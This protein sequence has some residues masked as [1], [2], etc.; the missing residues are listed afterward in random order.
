LYSIKNTTFSFYIYLNYYNVNMAF[1]SS[2]PTQDQV[3]SRYEAT[4]YDS[5]HESIVEPIERIDLTTTATNPGGPLTLWQS[6]T[7]GHLMVGANDLQNASS[8]TSTGASTNDALVRW[9]GTTGT[10]IQNSNATLTDAGQLTTTLGTTTQSLQ[11]T[12]GS[13]LTNIPPPVP[14]P[15][16]IY[17]HQ[18]L[19]Y[20]SGVNWGG[21]FTA[22]N[23]ISGSFRLDRIAFF[24]EGTFEGTATAASPLT[25]VAGTIDQNF[26]PFVNRMVAIPATVNG[27]AKMLLW[28]IGT[29]GSMS[30]GA[31]LKNTP[32]TAF[33]INDVI[34][35]YDICIPYTM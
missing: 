3:H 8:V 34:V 5:I 7:T 35:I 9:N 15:T 30:I 17:Y 12:G 19:Q 23:V 18:Q 13:L 31:D 27:V 32:T 21:A 11:L 25:A 2:Q 14:A 29:D 24:Q 22:N 16:P 26:R 10:S 1:K 20:P 33:A 28:S 6:S 4:H